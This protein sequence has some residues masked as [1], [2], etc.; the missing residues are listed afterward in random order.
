MK[1]AIRTGALILLLLMIGITALAQSDRFGNIAERQRTSTV[2]GG[3]GMF[4]TF[5]TR[6]LYKGEFNFALFWNNFDRGPGAIDINQV[7]FNITVGLTDRWELWVDW[8]TWQQTT[9]RQPFLL[10]RPGGRR[11]QRRRGVLPRHRLA[12]RRN[13]SGARALRAAVRHG[14]AERLAL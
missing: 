8:V 9:S 13:T 6:T 1:S 5:S 10:A 14:D 12:R 2:L 11:S 7:P 4:N 3:T